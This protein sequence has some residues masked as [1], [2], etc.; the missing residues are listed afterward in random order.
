MADIAIVIVERGGDA[1]AASDD[2]LF[3]RP[4][5]AIRASNPISVDI[6]RWEKVGDLNAAGAYR[7]INVRREE[8]K[9]LLEPPSL[10]YFQIERAFGEEKNLPGSGARV[11]IWH[12]NG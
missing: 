2:R 6:R 4:F 8:I 10:F 9:E 12:G 7:V 11:G 5:V 3:P 1:R